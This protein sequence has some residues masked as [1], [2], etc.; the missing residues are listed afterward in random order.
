M[1]TG[2]ATRPSLR[3]WLC[4]T[5]LIAAGAAVLLQTDRLANLGETLGLGDYIAYWSAGRL[6][7]SGG[8]PYSPVELLP[9]QQ[10]LGWPDDFPNMMYYPPW[11]LALVMPFGLLSFGVSRMAWLVLNLIVAVFAADRLWSYFGGPAKYRLWA[12]V[13][14]L[15][16][17]PTLVVLRIGQIG[18]LLLLGV[19]GFLVFERRRQGWLAGAVLL[20]ATIKPHLVYLFGLAVLLWA[21][22]RR[23]WSVLMGGSLAALAALA[24]A[25]AC[26]PEALDQYRYAVANPPSGNV[27]P[28]FGAL[29][30]LVLGE[31][32]AWLQF[33]PSV[34]GVLWF[35][36]YWAKHRRTW[37]WEEQAPVLLLVSFLTTSY[38]SWVFDL[39]VLL[40]PI[41]QAAVWA[42]SSADR[43]LGAI[44]LGSYLAIDGLA[45]VLN[46]RQAVYPA[47]I[48]M[49]PALL[50]AYLACR[51]RM[52]R[53]EPFSVPPGERIPAC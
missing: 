41:L 3:P 36:F 13:V 23:R 25:L 11:T 47:F 12:W 37:A 5:I 46:L 33:V 18:P 35:A 52:G 22:D 28:T 29:L 16:F 26:N 50:V 53:A 17:V 19:A 38:G 20:L 49:T 42:F 6:N 32:Q 21:V 7:A 48:W 1:A 30:R 2:S 27:T 15:S 9:L 44:A 45:L 51:R 31:D 24:V 34:F 43:R 10:E 8:N 4:W 40:V 39:V 14:A